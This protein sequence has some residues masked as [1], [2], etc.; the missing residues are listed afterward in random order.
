R[1]VH[2]CA[3]Y[4][5]SFKPIRGGVLHLPDVAGRILRLLIY[6]HN[7]LVYHYGSCRDG[8]HSSGRRFLT[9]INNPFPDAKNR[10]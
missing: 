3:E 5:F 1:C 4:E 6:I 8:G 2:G 7:L 9:S 10:A